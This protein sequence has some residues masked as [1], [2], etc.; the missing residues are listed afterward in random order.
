[1]AEANTILYSNYPPI[2][3]KKKRKKANAIHTH[4]F[5]IF[6]VCLL[7]TI[8]LYLLL[9]ENL[10]LFILIAFSNLVSIICLA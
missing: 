9:L 5:F 1:M 8:S 3:K 7:A 10:D 6:I 4:K 2:K